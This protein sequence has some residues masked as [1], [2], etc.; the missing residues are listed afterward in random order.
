MKRVARVLVAASFAVAVVPAATPANA[1][2]CGDL[3]LVCAVVCRAG[4]KY[5]VE[6]GY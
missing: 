4:Q 3:A 1:V 6:C 5:G 2:D